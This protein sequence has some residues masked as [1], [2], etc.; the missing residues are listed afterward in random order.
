MSEALTIHA[1]G[2]P[3]ETAPSLE[4]FAAALG[5]SVGQVVSAL[6][7]KD[8]AQAIHETTKA[9]ALLAQAPIVTR[10]I[11]IVNGNDDKTALSAAALLL[12]LGG[13]LKGPSV[14]VKLSFDE[15]MKSAAQTQTG[16]LGG[17]T[18][19]VEGAAIDVGEDDADDAI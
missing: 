5:L 11:K 10:L 1:G 16:P 15:L 12:K 14:Q 19:I 7:G 2:L 18:Q 13:N 4:D 17:I 6:T 8:A 9:R 3:S